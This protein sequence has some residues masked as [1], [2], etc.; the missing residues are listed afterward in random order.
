MNFVEVQDELI[1]KIWTDGRTPRPNN[2]VHVHEL[3]YT[4]KLQAA[5]WI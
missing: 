5:S 2:P 4:S 3:E 1:D